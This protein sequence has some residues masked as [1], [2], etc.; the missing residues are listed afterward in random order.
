FFTG[1]LAFLASI[2]YMISLAPEIVGPGHQGPMR[3]ADAVRALHDAYE[4]TLNLYSRII[5]EKKS[6]EEIA[7]D[8]FK[9]YYRDEFTIYS[10]ENIKNCT[11]LLVRR[12][13]ENEAGGSSGAK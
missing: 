6:D 8:L 5:G 11:R 9:E 10:E 12:A 1:F 4:A 13:R 7:D 2:E 3:G